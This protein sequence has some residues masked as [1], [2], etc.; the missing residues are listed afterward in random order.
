MKARLASVFLVM[1]SSSAAFSICEHELCRYQAFKREADS[2]GQGSYIAM[3]AGSFL[4]PIGACISGGSVGLVA[5][6]YDQMAKDALRDYNDC[7]ARF[8]RE[9]KERVEAAQRAEDRRLA[10][11]LRKQKEKLEN[12]DI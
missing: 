6:R 8:N 10:E 5:A 4:G 12:L 2:W 7:I 11:E 3:G 1:A 9:A